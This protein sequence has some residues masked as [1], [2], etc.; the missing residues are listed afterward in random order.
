MKL[1]KTAGLLIMAVILSG[2]SSKP[3]FAEVS[4]T[5]TKDGK[6][7]NSVEVRFVP[8]DGA[9]NRYNA[10]GVSDDEGKFTIAI[11]GHEDKVCCVGKCKVTVR[12]GPIPNQLRADLE[13]SD[14]NVSRKADIELK[15][16]K[17]SLKNRPIP[18]EYTRLHSTPL[19]P[20]VTA[21]TFEFLIEL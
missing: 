12:E 7:V 8:V 9:L 2:C 13:S 10:F 1:S 19:Q 21:G 15:R 4:G 5:I 20:D 17:S 11:P 18:K 16:F 6:P 14:R 3:E